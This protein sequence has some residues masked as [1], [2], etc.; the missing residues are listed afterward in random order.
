[1]TGG[2]GAGKAVTFATTAESILK[3]TG[4]AYNV[5]PAVFVYFPWETYQGADN[6]YYIRDMWPVKNTST[7][8]IYETLAL[9]VAG[10]QPGETLQAR[11]NFEITAPVI[12]EETIIFDTNGKTV[13]RLRS[14]IRL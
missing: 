5:N 14:N 4:G 7:G 6:Y 8:V 12:V 9:A 10:A 2:T 11:R 3:L 13:T 1:M